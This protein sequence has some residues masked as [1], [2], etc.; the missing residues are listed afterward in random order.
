MRGKWTNEE[1]E[2]ERGRGRRDEAEAEVG[3]TH[4]QILA[5]TAPER[6]SF[7]CEMNAQLGY[8]L[9]DMKRISGW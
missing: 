8:V 4:K 5:V 7:N 3:W 9:Q 6:A 1:G 2:R